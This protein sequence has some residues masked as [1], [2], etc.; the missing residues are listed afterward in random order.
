MTTQS[1][2]NHPCFSV[3]AHHKF[4]R[5]HLPVAPV[6]NI[7]CRYCIRKY[8]CLSESRPGVT[9]RILT[10]YEAFERVRMISERDN[11]ITVIG[12]A[13]PGD[14]LSNDA[15]IETLRLI[16]K[17]F[18]DLI[19][20]I[21]TNGLLLL[22]KLN[23]IVQ[24]GV[25]SLTITINAITTETADKIYS[26]VIYNGITLEGK[27]GVE[28]LLNNQ[29]NGLR[30]AIEAGL[31]VK[32]NT[33]YIPGINDEDIPLIAE[34][35]GS[36]GASIMNIIPIY[37]QADFRNIQRPNHTQLNEMRNLCKSYISQMT[38]CRQCRADALG[39]FGEDRDIDGEMLNA[40]I[41][42]DEYERVC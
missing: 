35:S 13:G 25:K 3:D 38:H 40:Y 15:A 7:Q 26:K 19:L 17:S 31:I 33:V 24:V 21:S 11:H 10:P 2:I 1:I 12:I 22:D 16:H 37:P 32:I 41:S 29:W 39:A 27:T 23:D 14:P 4:G 6:C 8:D 36:T 34:A 28:L 30:C 18:S 9:S 20:C 42:E 5:L